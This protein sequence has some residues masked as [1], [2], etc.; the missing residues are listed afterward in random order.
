LLGTWGWRW[1]LFFSL[2]GLLLAVEAQVKRAGRATGLSL[3]PVCCSLAVLLV[4][5]VTAD[6]CFW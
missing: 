2:Q 6:G 4:L 1:L 5:G 3:H